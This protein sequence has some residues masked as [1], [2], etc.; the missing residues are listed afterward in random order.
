MVVAFHADLSVSGGSTGV[1]VFFVISGF[2]ISGTL[3]RELETAGQINLPRFYGRRVK[4]LFPALAAML[5]VVAA[6][7]ALLNPIGV[8]HISAMT[9]ISASL[10]GANFYLYTL[11]S[12]YFAIHTQLN[13]L[14]HTWTL[15]VEEQFYLVFPTVLLGGWWLGSQLRR[16]RAIAALLIGALSAMLFLLTIGWSDGSSSFGSVRAPA[17]FAFYASPARAWEFGAGAILALAIPPLRRLPAIGTGPLAVLGA[18]AIATACARAAHPG[19]L[20][21][22]TL[23][24]AVAG[25]CALIAAGTGASNWISRLL[26]LRLPVVLGD[27]SYSWYLWHWPLIVFAVALFPGNGWAAPSGAVLSLVPAWCS[28]RYLEKPV[29]RSGRLQGRVIVALA[30]VCVAM[31]IFASAGLAAI[32]THLPTKQAQAMHADDALGCDGAAP[33]GDPSRARCTWKVRHPRGTVVLIGD[34]NAGHFTEPVIAAANHAGF[35]AT[36]AT[37]SGCPFAQLTQSDGTTA[38]CAAFNTASLAELVRDR[39]ALVI[40]GSRTDYYVEGKAIALGA[41][42]DAREKAEIFAASLG[43]ELAALSRAGIPAIVV[44]PIPALPV[45]Q[46]ACAVLLVWLDGCRGTLPRRLVD[47]RLRVARQAED[48]AMKGKRSV[49]AL[50]LEDDLCSATECSSRRPTGGVVMYRNEDHLSV[51]GALTL[52][53]TF[54][55]AIRVHARLEDGDA[56]GPTGD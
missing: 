53:R 46:Q 27:L 22:S 48:R 32:Q 20:L 31:P 55:E 16:P 34:S 1:D 40:I 24:F 56:A 30:A 13:P 49:W 25:S 2:V 50:D 10:F 36:V 4:R 18:A 12:G 19:P 51:A 3:I 26:G 7:G 8:G 9:G 35:N 52:T 47:E 15:A 6:T 39:P 54:Y 45:D 37:L 17:T 33:L 14:L 23:L 43:G 28:Y 21:S 5:V 41:F 11:P 29:R 42:N 38:S 44:H